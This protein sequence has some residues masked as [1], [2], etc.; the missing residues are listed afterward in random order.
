[1]KVRNIDED[2]VTN[3]DLKKLFAKIGDLVVCRFDRNDFGVFLGS[4]TV[5]YR[6]QEDAKRAIEEY[7]EAFLD[8][9]VLTVEFDMV[10]NKASQNNSGIASD[11]SGNKGGPVLRKDPNSASGKGKTLRLKQK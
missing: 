5:E 6:R 7:H 3:N 8:D 1:M 10:P 9:K 2:Q 11:G 4:A